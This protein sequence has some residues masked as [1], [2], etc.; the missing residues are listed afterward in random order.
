MKGLIP[1][2]TTRLQHLS[3]IAQQIEVPPFVAH[4][5]NDG[6]SVIKHAWFWPRMATFYRPKDV[7]IAE[8]GTSYFGVVDVPMPEGCTFVSQM[9]W[10]SI[11]W[12]VGSTLG[13]AL[14]AREC[15][16]GRTILFI[17]DGSM[18]VYFSTTLPID[19]LGYSLFFLPCSQLTVQ[20]LSTM[21]RHDLKPIIFLLNNSGYTIER[22]LHGKERKYNDIMNWK[23]TS[24]L[25][26]LGDADGTLSKSYTVNTRAELDELLEQAEFSSAEKI[27]LVEV[28]MPQLDAPRALQVQ[29]ELSVKTN[30][31]S[32]PA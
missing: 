23:W 6:D 7:I 15:N 10:G 2:L 19:E 31:Y 16:L 5:P 18:Y 22:Y 17:G 12:T 25:T 24:L 11:G 21:I 20:E 29:A 9:L 32:Q 1:K 27:Q 4:V 26:T 3:S 30:S 13:A 14:A 8:T 28:M